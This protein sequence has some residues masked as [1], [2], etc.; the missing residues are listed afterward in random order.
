M[1]ERLNKLEC[2]QD[3]IT[4][5]I[6]DVEKNLA[7]SNKTIEKESEKIY[8]LKEDFKKYCIDTSLAV[9]NLQ[10]KVKNDF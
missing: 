9:K 7:K 8:N 10:E 4:N 1:L 6:R 3:N 2:S 5:S